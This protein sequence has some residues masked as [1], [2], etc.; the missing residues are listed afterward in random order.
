MT[1]I[2]FLKIGDYF[3]FENKIYK[4]SS[5]ISNTNSYVACVDTN[6]K[7]KRLYIGTIVE[8]VNK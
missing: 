8:E 2:G 6:G 1:E 7:V 4:V 3:E 5:L